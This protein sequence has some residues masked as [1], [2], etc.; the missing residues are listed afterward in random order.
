MWLVS[1]CTSKRDKEVKFSARGNN[2]DYVIYELAK[3]FEMYL[4]RLCESLK[5]LELELSWWEGK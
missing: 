3:W 1:A 2:E 4:F 5:V